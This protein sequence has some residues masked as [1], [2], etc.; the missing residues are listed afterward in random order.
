MIARACWHSTWW[1]CWVFYAWMILCSFTSC[2]SLSPGHTLCSFRPSESHNFCVYFSVVK[3]SF[4]SLAKATS[5]K[6]WC[7][8]CLC[9]HYLLLPILSFFPSF[10]LPV[11]T[12]PYATA[13]LYSTLSG[14]IIIIIILTFTL[15]ED[16]NRDISLLP[17]HFYNTNVLTYFF[18]YSAPV[19]LF[20]SRYWPHVVSL[21]RKE[22]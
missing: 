20:C 12:E 1:W 5:S 13:Y 8:P 16:N 4:L 17:N 15:N 9:S 14:F 7:C 6:Y 21:I 11:H 18:Y 2:S 22:I 3:F 10:H 19:K